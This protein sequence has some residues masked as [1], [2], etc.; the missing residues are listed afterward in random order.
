LVMRQAMLMRERAALVPHPAPS[1]ITPTTP[2]RPPSWAMMVA[3]IHAG[4]CQSQGEP[5]RRDERPHPVRFGSR[6]W[7]RRIGTGSRSGVSLCR[8]ISGLSIRSYCRAESRWSRRR[9]LHHQT[10]Q[11]RT[12]CRRMASRDAGASLGCGA[13]RAND[14]R[15]DRR[16]AGPAKTYDEG[17]IGAAPVSE[18]VGMSQECQ[19]R[20]RLC[21]GR[22]AQ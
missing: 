22:C 7:S 8:G 15:W 6:T 17:S 20:H 11:G 10:A 12:R 3:A 13:R 5:E 2:Q 4:E 19:L 9:A 1:A 18:S 21:R 16:D 14:V